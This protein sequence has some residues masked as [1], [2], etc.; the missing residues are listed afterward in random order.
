MKNKKRI[1][2][3]LKALSLALLVG[4]AF[5]FVVLSAPAFAEDLSNSTWPIPGAN[6]RRSYSVNQAG[7]DVFAE[8]ANAVF[9]FTGIS[10]GL[11]GFNA[12]NLPL[13]NSSPH[14]WVYSAVRV[15]GDNFVPISRIVDTTWDRRSG[16]V[17]G[18]SEFPNTHK[19]HGWLAIDNSWHSAASSI[20]N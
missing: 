2:K 5:S 12:L 14:N 10:F 9:D 18:G 8:N 13:S 17:S 6:L 16:L 15:G 7:P 3:I 4:I 11:S 20:G 19:W 1:N